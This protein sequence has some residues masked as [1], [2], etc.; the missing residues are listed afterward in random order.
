VAARTF[1]RVNLSHDPNFYRDRALGALEELCDSY[2][3][4]DGEYT[5]GKGVIGSFISDLR[6]VNI[7]PN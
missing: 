5:S 2:Y 4:S 6:S 1:E 7:Y 3:D